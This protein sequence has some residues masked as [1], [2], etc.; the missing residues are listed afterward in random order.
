MLLIIV[1]LNNIGHGGI[2]DLSSKLEACDQPFQDTSVPVVMY[3]VV[4]ELYFYWFLI[5]NNSKVQSKFPSKQSIQA[6]EI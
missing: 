2:L 5:Y 3:F 6:L 4:I 1:I